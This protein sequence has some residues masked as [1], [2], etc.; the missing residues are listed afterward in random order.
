[1]APQGALQATGSQV[2]G[3]K[4]DLS[5]NGVYMHETGTT[6]FPAS[7]LDDGQTFQLNRTAS[8]SSMAS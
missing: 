5:F 6:S 3:G 4:S 8:C 7:T 1:M 2:M